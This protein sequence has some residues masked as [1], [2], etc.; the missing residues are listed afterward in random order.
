MLI[1]SGLVTAIV[2]QLGVEVEQPSRANAAAN[3]IDRAAESLNIPQAQIDAVKSAV[4]VRLMREVS[5][6]RKPQSARNGSPQAWP[7]PP[8]DRCR[9]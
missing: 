7:T 5:R 6:R 9:T 8:G 3:G 2:T 4:A 1:R